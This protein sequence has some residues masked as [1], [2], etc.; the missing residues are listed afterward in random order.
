MSKPL[1][2]PPVEVLNLLR[3]VQLLFRLRRV[4]CMSSEG[5][6]FLIHPATHFHPDGPASSTMKVTLT[7]AVMRNIAMIKDRKLTSKGIAAGGKL[8]YAT[9]RPTG[10][11]I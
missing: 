7:M 2:R 5:L 11:I 4:Q 3:T 6:I 10:D 9:T 8:K 1:A